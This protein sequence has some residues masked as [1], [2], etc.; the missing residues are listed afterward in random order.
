VTGPAFVALVLLIDADEQLAVGGV[1]STPQLAQAAVE[2]AAAPFRYN[3][4]PALPL[5]VPLFTTMIGDIPQ[6]PPEVAE[7][8]Q[9][10]GPIPYCRVRRPGTTE[11]CVLLTGHTEWT[12]R[13]EPLHQSARGLR[14]E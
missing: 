13:P 10:T 7:A 2:S 3:I 6:R 8:T 11:V 12:D 4:L 5:D 9:K 14:W 1:F